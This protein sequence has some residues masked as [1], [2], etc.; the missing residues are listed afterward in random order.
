MP[1]N[2]NAKRMIPPAEPRLKSIPPFPKFQELCP[3]LASR[4]PELKRYDEAVRQWEERIKQ[5]NQL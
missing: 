4:F 3:D 5:G 2:P 1:Q